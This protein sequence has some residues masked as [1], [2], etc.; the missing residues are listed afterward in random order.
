MYIKEV[1]LQGFRNLEPLHIAPTAGMNLFYGDNAQ[2]VYKRQTQ[3]RGNLDDGIGNICVVVADDINVNIRILENIVQCV[4][5]RKLDQ[6]RQAAAHKVYAVFLLE[7][8]QF[9]RHS[10]LRHGVSLAFVFIS[11]FVHLRLKLLHLKGCLLY[12]SPEES[13]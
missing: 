8:L 9:Q 1:S 10:L 6:H 7:V 5:D 11:D 2:D 12:T 3:R 4:Q 13:K